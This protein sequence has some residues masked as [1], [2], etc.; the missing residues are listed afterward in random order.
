MKVEGICAAE[1]L[2]RG[3]LCSMSDTATADA[4]KYISQSLSHFSVNNEQFAHKAANIL[5]RLRSGSLREY[6]LAQSA[7]TEGAVIDIGGEERA[8]YSVLE[9]SNSHTQHSAY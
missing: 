7:G 9:V 2:V 8:F 6:F 1:S 4:E 5:E 3:I